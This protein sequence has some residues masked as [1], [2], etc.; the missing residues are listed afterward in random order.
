MKLF[1][2]SH[3][4]GGWNQPWLPALDSPETLV[5]AFGAARLDEEGAALE[6]LRR[7]YPRSTLV[8]CSTAGEIFGSKVRDDSL[9]VAVAHFEKSRIETA[10]REVHGDR[11][12]H[13]AGRELAKQLAAPDLRGVLVFADGLHVNRS[14]L[15]RGLEE[16]LPDHAVV[17]G[18]M[19]GDGDRFRATWVLADRRPRQNHVCAVGLYGDAVRIR[20][21]SSGNLDRLAP[22]QPLATPGGAGAAGPATLARPATLS[23]ADGM[24]DGAR[25]AARHAAIAEPCAGDLLSL[26]ILGIGRRIALRGRAERETEA[27]FAELAPK[28]QQIGFYSYGAILPKP[29]GVELDLHHSTMTVTSLGEA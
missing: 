5:L 27:V 25:E 26:A 28:S 6:E 19:A 23:R 2:L 16:Q 17:A 15:L 12:S 3:E 8:G 18:G 1:T 20:S 14:D 4:K 24:V 7:A 13:E 29:G 10:F 9:V 21:G 22:R 11:D